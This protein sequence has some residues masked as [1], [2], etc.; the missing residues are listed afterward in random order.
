M[1]LVYNLK[2][3]YGEHPVLRLNTKQKAA[4]GNHKS[5]L[6]LISK[7]ASPTNESALQNSKHVM[8]LTPVLQNTKYFKV[9]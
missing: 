9:I 6:P 5:A 1:F 3:L 8:D 4:A 2:E 7:R